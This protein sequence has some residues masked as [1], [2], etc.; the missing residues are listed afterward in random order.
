MV[1]PLS[2]RGGSEEFGRCNESALVE[3]ERPSSDAAAFQKDFQTLTRVM[4]ERLEPLNLVAR[5]KCTKGSFKPDWRGMTRLGMI[6]PTSYTIVSQAM[7]TYCVIERHRV[8]FGSVYVHNINAIT[9]SKKS[10][11]AA[12]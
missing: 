8:T 4:K 2:K 6:E 9:S 3:S 1:R 5:Q 7:Q 10:H 11:V 12:Y